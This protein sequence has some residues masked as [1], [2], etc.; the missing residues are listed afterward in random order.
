LIL[1]NPLLGIISLVYIAAILGIAGG[2]AAI[3]MA[4]KMRK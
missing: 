2:I 4:I 1:G 3:Y